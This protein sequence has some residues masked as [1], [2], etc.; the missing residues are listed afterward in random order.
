VRSDRNIIRHNVI[1][2]AFAR[3]I[4]LGDTADDNEVSSNWI[5][6][7]VDGAVPDVNAALKCFRSTMYDAANW[8]GGW[9]LLVSGNRNKILNNRIAGL[10]QLQSANDTPPMAL[11][12]FGNDHIIQDNIIG[13][14]AEGFECGTCGQG[15]KVAGMGTDILSNTIVGSRN[16]FENTRGAILL[17]DSSPLFN[18]VT[19][20]QNIVKDGPAVAIEMGPAI[21][22]TL[23]RFKPAQIT[24]MVGLMVSGING[25][26]S[27]CPSC[28]ID[29]YLDDLDST[30]EALQYLGSAMADAAGNFVFMLSQALPAGHGIRT[31][32][33]T[34]ADDVIGTYDT[35]TSTT[36]SDVVYTP[37][38]KQNQ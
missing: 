34:T 12:I 16:G 23:K 7:R 31:G 13:V 10:H 33:T 11:E 3:A 25:D 15:I 17:N 6:T 19:V 30:Q 27:P 29:F 4:N 21:P 18:Q 2:G 24:G 9:G 35:G 1:T 37:N 14:D 36:L 5:G 20:R 8:Y 38:A 32:S 22:T 26:A 28:A